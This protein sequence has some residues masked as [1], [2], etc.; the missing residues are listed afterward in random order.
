MVKW[1]GNR[2]MQNQGG[3]SGLVT[4]IGRTRDDTVVW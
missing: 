4:E 3:Y 2:E 1:S